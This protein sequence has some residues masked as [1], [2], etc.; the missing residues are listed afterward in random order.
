MRMGKMG[1]LALAGTA[2]VMVAP[3]ALAQVESAR[4]FDMPSQDLGAA[5]RAVAQQSGTQVI[6]PTEL[7][8][9]LQAPAVK[10]RYRPDQAVSLLLRGSRLRVIVVGGTLVVQRDDTGQ[11]GN[12]P[13]EGEG[14][15]LVT[16]TRI[17]GS[18]PVGV[19]VISIGREQIAQG[20]FAT[21]QQ[22]VQSIPQNFAGGANEGT[23]E[24]ITGIGNGNS[25]RGSGVN[26]RGLGQVSTLVLINGDRPPL[27]GGGGTFGDISMIPASIIERIEIVPDGSSAIYGSDAV[28]GVVNIIPRLNFR[29]AETSFRIGTAGGDSQEYQFSQLFGARWTGG[30]AVLAYE[31]YKR[32]RLRAADRDFATDDLRPFGGP[33]RRSNFA[34]PGTIVAGGVNFAIPS[35]QNGVGLTAGQL[36]RGVINRGDGWYGTDILPEQRRHSVFAAISQDLTGN[37]K[38]YANGLATW[39]NYDQATRAQSNARRT[40]PVTNAFYLDPIG[41]HLPVGVDYS[42][43]RDLGAERQSGQVRAFGATAGLEASFGAWSVD[44]HGTWG[45][46][47]ESWMLGNRV[48]TARLALAL[49]DSN[50]STAYNLFGDGPS[51]NPATIDSIRGYTKNDYYGVVWSA[52]LRADGPLF[53]LPA[54]DLRLAVGGDYHEDRYGYGATI[55]YTS[56]LTPTVTPP[57]P[58]LSVRRVKGVYAEL[59]VPV[60]GGDATLAGFHRLDLSAAVRAEDYSD[61]GRTTNPKLGLSWEPVSGI[62]LRGSYGKSFRAP[63]FTELRQDPGSIAI[64]GYPAADPQAAGGTSNILVIRGNDPNLRPE[65]ATTWTLGG[66]LEPRFLPGLRI[67]AT[68]FNVDYRDR[69]AT[70]SANIPNFL[71]NRDIYAPILEPNPSAARVAELLASPYYRN[72]FGIPANA[73]FVAVADARLQNL[74]VVKQSG[75]DIDLS[76]GFDLAGGH[77]ELGAVGTFIFN[78][79]QQLTATAAAIDVVDTVGNP[80]DLRL[81][82][83][84]VW[85]KG[86]FS[87][88]LFANYVDGYT[89][90][91]VVPSAGVAAWTTFDLNIGFD[92]GQR[93]GPL[94]GLRIAINASNLL[95]ADPPY[96]SYLAG[97]YTAAYDG[98][99]ASPLGRVL[100]I[101]IT[102]K[103]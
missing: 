73:T 95:D 83:R 25:A 96:V 86:G 18:G 37:L 1:A 65:R 31:Y 97:S 82:A 61:F 54:G 101:Q 10:G 68:Y 7:V 63:T 32:D 36:S 89:N 57:T 80:V 87:A 52:T 26:L 64:F 46:Q 92:F 84:A 58:L 47:D 60:F 93:D 13:A 19:P 24:L 28:A 77:A 42:F 14:E 41:T 71:I 45:R 76:Y 35:G 70:P 44:A 23:G 39:R 62:T 99:N 16:G 17:R 49:A 72:F 81:R 59:R 50:P 21:T 100:A 56:T 9:G 11:E 8:A 4:E 102:K 69:I 98:E 78:I 20:G 27:G 33:D 34:S 74:S 53:H 22:I 103:W 66:D 51:T 38:F 94:G 40:V 67:G 29:G 43:T 6:A 88:A 79:R 55:S 85:S 90:K 48:N 3:A 91:L 15:I 5:L 30:H 75:L 2:M 12:G